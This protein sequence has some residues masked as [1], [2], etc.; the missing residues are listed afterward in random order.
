[1]IYNVAVWLCQILHV[2]CAGKSW[3]MSTSRYVQVF[4]ESAIFWKLI[5][6]IW[7]FEDTAD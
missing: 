1:M 5:A 6:S 3:L 2:L 7:T 4:A